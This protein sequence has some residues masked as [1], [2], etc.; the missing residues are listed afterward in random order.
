MTEE[1]EARNDNAKWNSIFQLGTVLFGGGIVCPA[2][3]FK[4][5]WKFPGCS[6]GHPLPHS[7]N[8]GIPRPSDTRFKKN[9][10]TSQN[11]NQDLFSPGGKRK[12]NCNGEHLLGPGHVDDLRRCLSA[13]YH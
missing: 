13:I 8:R 5:F 11:G 2:A 9:T 12:V 6:R 10:N 7:P 3:R 1:G 4:C